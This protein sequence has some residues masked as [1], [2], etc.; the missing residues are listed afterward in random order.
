MNLMSEVGE[1]QEWDADANPNGMIS[2][3]GA[4]NLIVNDFFEDF[5]KKNLETFDPSKYTRYGPETGSKALKTAMAAFFNRYFQPANL[6]TA[7][8][9]LVTNGS[10]SMIENVAWNIFDAGDGIILPTPTYALYSYNLEHR[11]N[12]KLLRVSMTEIKDQFHNDFASE[13]VQAFKRTYDDATRTGIKVKGLL[14]CNPNNPLGR[15]YSKQ[16]ILEIAKFC[17]E[18]NLHLISDEVFAMSSFDNGVDKGLDTFTS[19][20]TVPNDGQYGLNNIH[21]LYGASKDFGMGGMR[22][23]FVVTRNQRLLAMLEKLGMYTWVTSA[24]DAFFTRFIGDLD[25]VDEYIGIFKK[26]QLEA[27][28]HA[29]ALFKKHNI[30]FSPANACVFVWLDL[31]GYLKYFTGVEN[32]ETGNTELKL[33]RYFIGK[34]VFLSPGQA[35]ESTEQGFFRF[36]TTVGKPMLEAAIQRLAYCLAKLDSDESLYTAA[37]K[38]DI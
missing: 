8:E 24:S 20:L 30:S 21:V 1:Q 2:V 17:S 35:S 37:G 38:L 11:A 36:T 16:T 10:S 19:A 26:R 9:I 23:G 25:L 18:H 3:A 31:R 12:V 4:K 7:K 27:Y 14:I 15:C 22:L 6:V 29:S 32:S 34:G 5:C 33:C 28:T 13:V